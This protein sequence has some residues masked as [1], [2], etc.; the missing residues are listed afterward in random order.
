MAHRAD[1]DIE[2]T[3]AQSRLIARV[4]TVLVTIPAAIDQI[5]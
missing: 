3:L 4:L 2:P 1:D 5:C